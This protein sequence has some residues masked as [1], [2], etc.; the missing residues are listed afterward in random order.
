MEEKKLDF[1]WEH[2]KILDNNWDNLV[3][4]VLVEIFG[5][6]FI[7][8]IKNSSWRCKVFCFLIIKFFINFNRL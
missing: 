8:P 4:A 7:I 2:L 1:L 5:I 6:N 3:N